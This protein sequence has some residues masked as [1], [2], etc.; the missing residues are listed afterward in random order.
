MRIHNC[1]KIHQFQYLCFSMQVSAFVVAN[2]KVLPTDSLSSPLSNKNTIAFSTVFGSK[3]GGVTGQRIRIKIWHIPLFHPYDSWSTSCKKILVPT[4]S[5][6]ATIGYKGH[7]LRVASI[8][9]LIANF[10]ASKKVLI[11]LNVER[12]FLHLEL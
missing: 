2:L 4:Q 5:S 11:M 9:F 6:F 10:V 1:S 7:F 3:Q 8:S 12:P